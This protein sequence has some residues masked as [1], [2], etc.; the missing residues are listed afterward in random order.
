MHTKN[1]IKCNKQFKTND[2]AH[3]LCRGCY[4]VVINPIRK[5]CMVIL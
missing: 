5:K 1:C 3:K 4:F 2:E